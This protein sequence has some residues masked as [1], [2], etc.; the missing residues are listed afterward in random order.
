[1]Q[2]YTQ[3]EIEEAWT[4]YESSKVLTYLD[5]GVKKFKYLDGQRIDMKGI[6]RAETKDLKT[7][8]SFPRFLE[9]KWKKT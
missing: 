5:N 3:T 8:M 1:M 4:K 6:T 9:K 7:V 2:S